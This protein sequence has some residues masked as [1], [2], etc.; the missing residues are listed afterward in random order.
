MS[1]V[2]N[3]KLD[4]S[5]FYIISITGIKKLAHIKEENLIVSFLDKIDVNRMKNNLSTALIKDEYNFSDDKY[6]YFIKEPK[7]ELSSFKN[8]YRFPMLT[9]ICDILYR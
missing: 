6:T 9:K 7:G 2:V 5:E 4:Y 3:R 8:Y 1:C